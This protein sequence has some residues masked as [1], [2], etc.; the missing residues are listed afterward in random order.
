M[1]MKLGI[2]LSTLDEAGWTTGEIVT[3]S[4]IIEPSPLGWALILLFVPAVALELFLLKRRV[5]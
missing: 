1:T 4:A 2:F 3:E 5:R